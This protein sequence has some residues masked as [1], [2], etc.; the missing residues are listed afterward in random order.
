MFLPSP[1]LE[2]SGTHDLKK[3]V[4]MIYVKP[5]AEP[6][7]DAALTLC[8]EAEAFRAS[9]TAAPDGGPL[10]AVYDSFSPRG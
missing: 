8:A 2:A 3:G 10:T 7:E 4:E 1:S 6:A 5:G 9:E